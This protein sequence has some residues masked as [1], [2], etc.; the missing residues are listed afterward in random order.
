MISSQM[1]TQSSPETKQEQ[2]LV[3]KDW[4]PA[5]PA[6]QNRYYHSTV[7]VD[8]KIVILN[9]FKTNNIDQTIP[10]GLINLQALDI[11]VLDPQ[12]QSVKVVPPSGN[13]ANKLSWIDTASCYWKDN[14]IVV[15]GG[16]HCDDD[17]SQTSAGIVTLKDLDSEHPSAHWQQIHPATKIHSNSRLAYIYEDKMYLVGGEKPDSS[18]IWSLDLVTLEWKK[19]E[20]K[21]DPWESTQILGRI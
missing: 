18:D 7:I 6:L 13:D 3:W 10:I 5:H 20:F 11:V 9:G 17:E 21:D 1:T 19:C 14:K 4:K 2:Q 12:R 8:H 15:I 16:F